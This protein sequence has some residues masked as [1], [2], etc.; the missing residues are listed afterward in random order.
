MT[1][2]GCFFFI[3]KQNQYYKIQFSE[4][5]LHSRDIIV[6]INYRNNAVD[7][8]AMVTLK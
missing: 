8:Y 2:T 7:N 5:N 4:L 3:T 1:Q 6:I